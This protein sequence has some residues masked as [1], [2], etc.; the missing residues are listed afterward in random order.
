LCVCVCVCVWYKMCAVSF[1]WCKSLTTYPSLCMFHANTDPSE[2]VL[3][4]VPQPVLARFVRIR[5]QSWKNGI[6][7]RFELYG[8]QIIDAPCSEMQGL[9][10]GLLPDAQISAS[11]ARDMLWSPGTPAWWPA[12]RAGSPA[13]LSPWLGRSGSKWTW[14][15]PGWSGGSLP[16]GRGAEKGQAARTTG[17]L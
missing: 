5:P 6:A 9:L 10:S 8:C 16:R 1:D 4:R 3:N 11:S 14:V 17:P 12:T 15:S 2:V 13:P 7:L